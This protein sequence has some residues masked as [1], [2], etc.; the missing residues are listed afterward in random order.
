MSEMK[1]S[2]N[3]TT[4]SSTE[5]HNDRDMYDTGYEN[6]ENNWYYHCYGESGELVQAK[7]EGG[8]TFKEAEM[9]FYEEH[10]GEIL[11][12]Q[13][14]RAIAMRK[15]DRV[16]D[17][18]E[19]HSKHMPKE[20]IVQLGNKDNQLENDQFLHDSFELIKKQIEDAGG[21][22]ISAS[23]HNDETTSH[24]HIRACFTDSEGKVNVSGC[25]REHGIED[26][27]RK[28]T[29]EELETVNPR[30]PKGKKYKV[31]EL[32]S[33]RYNNP[34]NTWTEETRRQLEDLGEKYA[35]INRERS[36]RKH[37]SVADYK[38]RMRYEERMAAAAEK[39]LELVEREKILDAR[40]INVET[41][42][43][44]VKSC[45][46]DAADVFGDFLQEKKN[47]ENA[48]TKL[49]NAAKAY[50]GKLAA[51]KTR[52]DAL[53]SNELAY[54]TKKDDI[55]AR[56]TA[57]NTAEA[58]LK[59]DRQAVIDAKKEIAESRTKLNDDISDFEI[60]QRSAKADV[61]NA[62]IEMHEF[63]KG[64]KIQDLVPLA[65]SVLASF[66]RQRERD[67]MAKF[68]KEVRSI[69]TQPD[70]KQTIADM[71]KKTLRDRKHRLEK[72]AKREAEPGYSALDR[73]YGEPAASAQRSYDG[74]T[75]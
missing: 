58:Q 45:E 50:E 1:V 9:R 7:P 31:G 6:S 3:V 17:M 43:T 56:E 36:N 26:G 57:L 41:R 29:A 2:F 34:L 15:Y 48:Q 18:E 75:L 49:D 32:K 59:T 52:E 47:A 72:A 27:E 66:Y 63:M 12:A 39:E 60:K 21:V 74:Q 30:R 73:S 61:E 5:D 42:E 44:N 65:L 20:F 53:A 40:E 22:V 68:F 37:E 46:Q 23:I 28:W 19:Y 51:L 24:L 54:K 67:D 25:M 33:K 13:N 11:R 16:M 64:T 62:A 71:F 35:T 8:L 38:R 10:F 14:E 69:V 55:E 4:A 70:T